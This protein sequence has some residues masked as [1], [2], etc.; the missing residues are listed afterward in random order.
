MSAFR[1]LVLAVMSM[2]LLCCAAWADGYAFQW[3]FALM[4]S[5]YNIYLSAEK[6]CIS[7][8]D[9]NDHDCWDGPWCLVTEHEDVKLIHTHILEYFTAAEQVDAD[10]YFEYYNAGLSKLMSASTEFNCHSYAIYGN[11]SVWLEDPSTARSYDCEPVSGTVSDPHEVG[12]ICNHCGIHSAII[13]EIAHAYGW[14]AEYAA[15]EVKS[16]CG[17]YGKYEHASGDI[18]DYGGVSGIYRK[19]P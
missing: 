17:A 19:K 15:A 11:S 12:M 7:Y 10:R 16:K 18:V 6:N 8:S 13:T 5:N 2:T 9:T 4:D 3:Q 14:G 1:M